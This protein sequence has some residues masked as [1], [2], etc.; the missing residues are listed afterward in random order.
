MKYLW[1]D[2]ERPVPEYFHGG[3]AES[4]LTYEAAIDAI[5]NSNDKICISFDNDLGT[6]KTGYDFAKWLI[7]H[8]YTG[9]FHIHSM[10][11]VGS[12]NIRQLLNHYGWTEVF[13]NISNKNDLT[14]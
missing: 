7:E 10:N 1:L 6:K 2:D 8:N 13:Y 3:A 4:V 9:Y 14:F 5:L 12:F 11:P